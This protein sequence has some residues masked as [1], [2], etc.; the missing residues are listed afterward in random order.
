VT[1]W[2]PL[3]RELGNWQ[4]HGR[5]ATLWLRDDDAERPSAALDGLLE[6]TAAHDVAVLL[7]IIPERTGAALAERLLGLRQVE[8]A[9]HGVAHR[10]HAPEG[11]KKA[12]LGAERPADII[13]AELGAARRRMAGLFPALSDILV[14]PWNRIAPAVAERIGEAGFTAIS[15]FGWA[16]AGAGVRQLNTHVDLIDWKDQR[17]WRAPDEVVML[18]AQALAAARGHHGFAPVGILTHHLRGNP[19]SDRLLD[20]ILAGTAR[21]P[22]LRWASAGDLV[23]AAAPGH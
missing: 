10:N 13:L 17:R 20:E 22:A 7:A 15:A 2:R 18:L 11:S 6:I 21:R 4:E 14:P 8:P 3:E 16:P 23:K 9:V 19:E 5:V 1:D 12:E